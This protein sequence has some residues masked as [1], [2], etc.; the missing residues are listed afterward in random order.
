MAAAAAAA[1]QAQ[2]WKTRDD[3]RKAKELEEA[4]KAGT[5]APETDEDGNAINPHIPQYISQA[6]CRFF[7]IILTCLVI[8]SYS[9]KQGI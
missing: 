2:T 8:T 5:A 3:H 1:Q 7:I 9:A 6:P 4:R